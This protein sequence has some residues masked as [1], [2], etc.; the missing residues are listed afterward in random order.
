MLNYLYVML[1][2]AIGTGTRFWLSGL[3]AAR[4]GEAFPLGTLIVNVTGCFLVGMLA[5]I[6]NPSG[7]FLVAPGTRQFLLLGICGG[8]TT[9]SS[10]SLQTVDLV[11]DGDW[12]RASLNV[13][14]SLILCLFAT[15]LGRVV[16]LALTGR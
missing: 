7:R 14:F 9:F 11:R 1:G 5:T 16:A 10:F 3:I 8:Y 15:W 2:G 13:G 4:Y 12:L 6:F